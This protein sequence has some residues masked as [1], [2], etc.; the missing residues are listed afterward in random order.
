VLVLASTSAEAQNLRITFGNPT[1][2]GNSSIT[3]FAEVPN[4]TPN[5]PATPNSGVKISPIIDVHQN[6]KVISEGVNITV[7]IPPGVGAV[8]KATAVALGLKQ[9]F[10][11]SVGRDPNNPNQ[12]TVIMPAGST[13]SV[14]PNGDTTGEGQITVAAVGGVAANFNILQIGWGGGRGGAGCERQPV[15]F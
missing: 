7:T 2:P 8:G 5:T 4:V 6:G 9:A 11:N 1:A 13:F 14:V 15:G 10:G 12:P 3:F